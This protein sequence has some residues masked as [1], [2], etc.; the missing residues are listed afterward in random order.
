MQRRTDKSSA[1]LVASICVA[2]LLGTWASYFSVYA[3]LP[4]GTPLA[5]WGLLMLALG[6]TAGLVI[7]LERV[8]DS[9][10]ARSRRQAPPET[11]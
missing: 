9:L 8:V 2:A 10:P 3:V 7:T 4:S 1:W 11:T 6:S 5:H